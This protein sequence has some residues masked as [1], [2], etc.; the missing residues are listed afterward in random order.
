MEWMQTLGDAKV[1]ISVVVGPWRSGKSF[2]SS[3]LSGR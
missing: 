2:L 1:S 3:L